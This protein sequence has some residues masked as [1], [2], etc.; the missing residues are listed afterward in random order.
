MSLL[1]LL[2]LKHK[3][4]PSTTIGAEQQRLLQGFTGFLLS[5]QGQI[6]FGK[7]EPLR[8]SETLRMK[9]GSSMLGWPGRNGVFCADPNNGTLKPNF[10]D[11]RTYIVRFRFE[12]SPNLLKMCVIHFLSLKQNRKQVRYEV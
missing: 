2:I 11:V 3:N 6:F 4:V 5:H 9:C 7:N 1:F 8:A 10:N 12:T